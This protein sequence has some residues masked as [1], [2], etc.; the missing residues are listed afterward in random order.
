M[1]YFIYKTTNKINGKYYIG[2]HKTDNLEDGYLGSGIHFKRALEKYGKENFE[3][4]ILEYCN[5]DEEMHL[6]EARYITEDVVNDKNS[7]NLK[8][9]GDGGWDYVNSHHLGTKNTK[10]ASARFLELL[11]NE[12]FYK[13][14]YEKLTKAKSTESYKQNMSNSLK[15]KW[16]NYGHPWTGRHHKESTKKKIGEVT[17]KAQ[18]GTGNSQYGTCWVSNPLIKK[19]IRIKKEFLYDYIAEGWIKKRII[20]W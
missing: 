8:L 17:S 12:E 11:K 18:K 16:K 19:S 6:A 5:Y 10:K 20:K 15:E 7:Y 1:Y 9:G 13:S 4:E 3:R 2:M 14:W